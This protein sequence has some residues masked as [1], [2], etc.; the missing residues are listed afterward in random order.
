MSDRVYSRCYWVLILA[1]VYWCGGCAALP[2]SLNDE[3]NRGPTYVPRNYF[4]LPKMPA[5]VARVVL[6]P[7]AA[8]NLA[9]EEVIAVIDAAL[10][11]SAIRTERFEVITL[12]RTDCRALL[13]RS[14]FR[15]AEA[16]P[17]SFLADL[18]QRTHADAVLMVELTSLKL[19]QPQSLGFRAR[20]A[21]CLDGGV[22]WSFDEVLSAG[23]ATVRNSARLEYFQQE[24][25]NRPYDFSLAGLQS[26]SWFAG[27]VAR[28][29]F[30]TLPPR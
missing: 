7:V 11:A 26:P 17:P 8:G 1:L 22:F 23:D 14:E 2:A 3:V 12:G 20:L 21:S 6:L 30:S 19:Y 27:F 5:G 29:M 9:P 4:A 25:G 10:A 15:L 24:H 16:L 13:G 18:K 28:Q